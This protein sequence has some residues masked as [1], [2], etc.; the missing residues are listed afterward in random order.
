MQAKLSGAGTGMSWHGNALPACLPAP[1]K[2]VELWTEVDKVQT[3]IELK[4]AA[5]FLLRKRN[6][7]LDMNLPLGRI[8][9]A[10]RVYRLKVVVIDTV[11]EIDHQVP[12]GESKTDCLGRFIM[13]LK[14]LANDHGCS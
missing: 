6:T 10:V 12:K 1:S 5:K 9:F 14:Q 11:N 3:D 8:E 7:L 2:P 13:R 4:Q